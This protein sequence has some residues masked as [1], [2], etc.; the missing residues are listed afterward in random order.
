MAAALNGVDV[1]GIGKNIFAV[2]VVVLQRNFNACRFKRI[3]VLYS[4]KI[5]RVGVQNL[6]VF[7]DI[8]N[9]F[10]N[11]AFVMEA[12]LHGRVAA[13]IRHDDAHAAV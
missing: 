5:N 10:N 6:F 7:V 1:V 3:I 11:P 13:F 8:A 4:G 2:A 9:V 12:V